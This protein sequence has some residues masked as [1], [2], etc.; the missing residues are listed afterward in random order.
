MVRRLVMVLP[1]LVALMLATVRPAEAFACG[2][3]CTPQYA[4]L[5]A[6]YEATAAGGASFISTGVGVV[7]PAGYLPGASAGVSVLPSA[8]GVSLGTALATA[9]GNAV[10]GATAVGL[11]QALK[12]VFGA[13]GHTEDGYDVPVTV[14][15][16]GG[17]GWTSVPKFNVVSGGVYSDVPYG[18]VA[19]AGAGVAYHAG[20][21]AFTVTA[22][23]VVQSGQTVS[24]SS[25]NFTP[26]CRRTSD[27][28]V[29]AGAVTVNI[30]KHAYQAGPKTYTDVTTS[31]ATCGTGTTFEHATVTVGS[32]VATWYPPG[33]PLAPSEGPASGTITTRVE[34][35][36]AAGVVTARTADGGLVTLMP[37]DDFDVPEVG[38]LEGEVP[39][40]TRVD[41]MGTDGV[42]ARPLVPP[43]ASPQWVQDLPS[44]YPECV[45]GVCTLRLLR[46]DVTPA[47][48]CLTNAAACLRWEQDPARDTKYECLYGVPSAMYAVPLA[49]CAVYRSV[50]TATATS[51][52]S[53]RP[54]AEVLPPPDVITSTE[55]QE[56]GA[57]CFPNGWGVLNPVEWVLKPTKCALE[58][59][60]VPP[61]G[62]AAQHADSMRTAWGASG[63]GQVLGTIGEIGAA[64]GGDPGGA[65][66]CRGVPV[67]LAFSDEATTVYPLSTCSPGIMTDIATFVRPFLTAAVGI[68]GVAVLLRALGAGFGVKE[69]D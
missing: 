45:D 57:D 67:R 5:T 36:T 14:T 8:A 25:V 68:G 18:T 7:T 11:V 47:I 24:A 60:F 40:S 39:V 19:V 1:V 4:L 23:Y 32:Y 26:R 51:T 48:D 59:A 61:E 69:A 12:G 52:G 6:E 41:W 3:L 53:P 65:V 31:A 66:D 62:S 2:S 50:P 38:C 35:K 9:G 34:C 55:A 30:M 46:V 21:G 43:T 28:V 13:S 27:G 22:S 15:P 29:V 56:E 54:D 17:A 64:A 37:G 44:M 63:P 42:T 58:W 49:R 20:P 33:H 10:A 16:P